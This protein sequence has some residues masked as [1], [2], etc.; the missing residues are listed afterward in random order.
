MR[1]TVIKPLLRGLWRSAL[2]LALCLPLCVF[3][4]DKDVL[5]GQTSDSAVNFSLE[6]LQGKLHQL[7][8][9]RGRWVLVNFW[10]TWCPPCLA[11]IPELSALHDTHKN[12]A[13]I[14]I[15]MDSGSATSVADFARKH[16]ISYPVVMGNRKVAAQIGLVNA[17][18]SSYLYNPAGEQDNCQAGVVTRTSIE[19]YIKTR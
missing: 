18:P 7:S 11:E 17:L 10:A 1:V 14:G 12:V 9:Y 6:D 8:D 16:G 4:V 19:N 13:V 5:C 15:A 2:C 3:A